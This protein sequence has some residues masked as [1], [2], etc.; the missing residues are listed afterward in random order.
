M[1]IN[2]RSI[3]QKLQLQSKSK[4]YIVVYFGIAVCIF[5]HAFVVA[6]I[7]MYSCT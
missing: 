2:P 1:S 4:M 5:K 7:I 6:V 3:L